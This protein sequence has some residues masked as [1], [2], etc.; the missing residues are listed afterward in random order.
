MTL[1]MMTLSIM[2]LSMMTHNLTTLSIITLSIIIFNVL[3]PNTESRYVVS[4]MFSG[5]FL[6]VM[7]NVIRLSVV[8]MSAIHAKCRIKMLRWRHCNSMVKFP[9]LAKEKNAECR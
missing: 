9:A 5:A 4:F 3:T 7:L 2:T 1:S 8:I 6:I